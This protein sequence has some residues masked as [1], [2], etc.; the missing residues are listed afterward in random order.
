M[1]IPGSVCKYRGK[2]RK[3]QEKDGLGGKRVGEKGVEIKEKK[4]KKK[5]KGK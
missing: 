4:R 5:E 2:L 1:R 3:R